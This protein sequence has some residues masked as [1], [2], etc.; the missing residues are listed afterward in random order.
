MRNQS[1]RIKNRISL[2]CRLYLSLYHHGVAVFSDDITNPTA[3][4]L[5]GCRLPVTGIELLRLLI[6]LAREGKM[7]IWQDEYHHHSFLGFLPIKTWERELADVTSPILREECEAMRLNVPDSLWGFTLG[8]ALA[9][10]L[11]SPKPGYKPLKHR[12]EELDESPNHGYRKGH[13]TPADYGK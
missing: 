13:H 2:K 7:V 10:V 12:E 6:E 3:L 1:P 8:I 11:P 4:E 9:A 5:C